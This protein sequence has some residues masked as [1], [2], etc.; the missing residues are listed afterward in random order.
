MNGPGLLTKYLADAKLTHAAF[1]AALGIDR[2]RIYRLASGERGPGLNLALDI[3][4]ETK[5]AIPATAWSVRG[6]KSTR[7]NPRGSQ[8]RQ[9]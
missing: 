7:R 3:E 4:R 2:Q 5:G 1:A 9:S 8:Q 6:S